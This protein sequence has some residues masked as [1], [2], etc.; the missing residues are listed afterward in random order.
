MAQSAKQAPQA[1]PPVQ[2]NVINVCTPSPEEQKDIAAVMGRIPSNP[3]FSPDFEIT[4]GRAASP[5]P[6]SGL[7]NWVRMR[8][9]FGA[10]VPFTSVQY[11]VTVDAKGVAETL[12]FPAKAGGDLVQVALED[13]VTSGTPASVLA[14]DTPVN[15]IRVERLGKGSRGLARCENADQSAYEPLFAQ[16]GD[17]MRRYRSILRVPATAGGELSRLG[18]ANAVAA[19]APAPKKK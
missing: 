9:E 3:A 11:A 15:R 5:P 19:H 7:S 4:R 17:I 18:V 10:G 6:D 12:V 8:R 1:T 16:A 14:S 13:R 2:V